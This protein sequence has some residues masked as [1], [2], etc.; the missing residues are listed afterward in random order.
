MANNDAIIMRAKGSSGE[1]FLLRDRVRI[2]QSGF[3]SRAKYGETEISLSQ[4]TSI[5]FKDPKFLTGRISFLFPGAGTSLGL[6]GINMR[7]T[8]MFTSQQKD[9]FEAI[10]KAIE[11]RIATLRIAPKASNPLDDLE[12][13]ASLRDK[14]IITEDEFRQKKKQI[15]GL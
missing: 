5:T 14:G 9:A 15:L 1:L 2:V 13:L 12:K 10:K 6:S 3:A 8:V 11:E 7:Y 4:I